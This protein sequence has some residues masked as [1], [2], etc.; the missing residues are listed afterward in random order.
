MNLGGVGL[1][2]KQSIAFC[3]RD[4]SAPVPQ[5]V[6]CYPPQT[7]TKKKTVTVAA[8]AVTQDDKPT[9]TQHGKNGAGQIENKSK[10][11]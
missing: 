3:L 5:N 10:S 6:G 2:F 8:A 1:L 4:L 7:E 9:L 11:L